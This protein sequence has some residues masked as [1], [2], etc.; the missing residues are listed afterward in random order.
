M[1][2]ANFDY[3][4]ASSIDE[5]ESLWKENSDAS[6]L[7]G[8]HSLIPAMKLRLSDPG[9]LVD[10]SGIDD[11]KG[12]SRDG[13]TIRI[14]ALT[15]HREVESSDVVKDGCSALSEAAG[16]IGDPQVRNRGTIGG[17]VAHADP[18]SDYPG[19][20]MALGATIVTSSRSIVV[21]DFFTG[22]FE[23]ALND[24][25][26][27]TEIQVP[28]IGSGSGAAY[29]KF[30]NP[31]SRYAVVGVG[32]LVSKSNGSCSS[33]RIGVT[34]AADHAFRASVAEEIL[35]G[36]DLGDDAVAASAAKVAD[37]QEMLGDLSASAN[38]RNHLCGVMAKRAIVEA[39]SRV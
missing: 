20:L 17:N 26:V 34:G 28:A 7:A 9:T 1:H 18:A 16:M 35:Q 14:G 30:F 6:F 3:H 29:T 27:I 33:C 37:G 5:A 21:D 38:Y 4:R 8:G 10:I 19:I 2:P 12:I 39:V 36:S 22:L 25:E 24:G 32:A 11:L 15:T 31:S 23:T 13:D